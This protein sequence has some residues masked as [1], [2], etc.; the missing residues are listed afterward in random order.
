MTPAAVELTAEI[1]GPIARVTAAPAAAQS[2]AQLQ[3]IT[4]HGRALE[5]CLD[6]P[7][8]D[9]LSLHLA[10]SAYLIVQP[11]A[12]PIGPGGH[13]HPDSDAATRSVPSSGHQLPA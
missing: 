7:T 8:V 13:H 9:R 6:A 11:R 3:D 2:D 5:H 10:R 12:E 1:F 4:K